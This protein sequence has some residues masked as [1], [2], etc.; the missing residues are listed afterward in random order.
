MTTADK[1]ADYD[2][3]I[4]YLKGIRNDSPVNEPSDTASDSRSRQ[5]S[6]SR[7]SFLSSRKPLP[8]PPSRKGSLVELEAALARETHLREEAEKKVAQVNNEIEDLSATLFEQANE[9][10]ATE[11]KA[12]AALEERVAT[13]QQ[14][15]EQRAKRLERIDEAMKRLERVKAM[16]AP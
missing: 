3:E 6:T 9:M 13:L 14:R 5:G 15:D 2:E 16:L 4:Q 10:V 11:R 1:L 8:A 7:F 12:R